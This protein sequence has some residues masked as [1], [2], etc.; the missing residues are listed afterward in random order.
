MLHRFGFRY[1][2][3]F[4]FQA[5]KA[6]DWRVTPKMPLSE[7][8]EEVSLL[9]GKTFFLTKL[10]NRLLALCKR[11]SICFPP[12]PVEQYV[13]YHTLSKTFIIVILII[14]AIFYRNIVWPSRFNYATKLFI[15]ALS[16]VKDATVMFVNQVKS[17]RR[18]QSLVV[19]GFP[20]SNDFCINVL[21]AF[22]HLFEK[23]SA[24]HHFVPS[25][26]PPPS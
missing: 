17:L 26:T 18:D 5:P 15:P 1:L 25:T 12:A 21:Y 19:F 13:P 4:Y 24:H 10:R 8:D 6:S 11:N 3:M 2:L 20:S 23:V 9:L 22:G 14:V 16:S 7:V